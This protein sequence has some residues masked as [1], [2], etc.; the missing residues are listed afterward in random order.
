MTV[1]KNTGPK[2]AESPLD[3][4]EGHVEQ[5]LLN[6]FW[7]PVTGGIV[8]FVATCTGNWVAKRPIMSGVQIHAL[9]TVAGVFLGNYF[10][11]LRDEYFA[12][13]DAIMRHYILLH[14][15]DFPKF[16]RRKYSEVLE[17]WY[18]AR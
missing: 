8:G 1:G 2:I 7:Y 18:P 17:K 14:P 10:D 13:K 16:E 6:K 5:P 15:E 9:M 4:F 3:L 12:E 11:K